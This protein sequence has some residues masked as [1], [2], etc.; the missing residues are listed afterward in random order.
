MLVNGFTVPDNDTL[1]RMLHKHGGDLETY[2]TTRI[3]HIIAQNLSTAKANMYKRQRKPKPVVRPDW[4]VDSVKAGRLL[5]HADYLI[6]EVQLEATSSVK[7]FF[8]KESV[9]RE[10]NKGIL[11]MDQEK[12]ASTSDFASIPPA[13]SAGADQEKSVAHTEVGDVMR[14]KRSR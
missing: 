13:Q 7:S 5:P 11:K 12:K 10:E 9:V 14:G 1:R 2:E 8:T 3:T 4:I 6:P